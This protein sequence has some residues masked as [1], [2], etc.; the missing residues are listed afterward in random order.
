MT[1]RLFDYEK[2]HVI[3]SGNGNTTQTAHGYD[4]Q[5]VGVS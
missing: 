5:S 2:S 3:C 4:A 1:S